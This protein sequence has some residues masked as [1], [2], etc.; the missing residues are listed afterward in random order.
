M[1]VRT[2]FI[3]I[4]GG[5]LA[6]VLLGGLIAACTGRQPVATPTPTRTPRPTETQ[7]PPATA[8]PIP[9][10][11]SA[12][13]ATPVATATPAAT[14]TPTVDVSLIVPGRDPDISPFTGLK[15]ADPKILERRPMAIK[16]ANQ[17]SVQPQSGLNKADIVVESPVEYSET[18]YTVLFHSQDAERVG[19]V[20]SARLIDVELPVIFDS[21][22]AYSGGVQPVLD[23]LAASD[24]G[25]QVLNETE[26]GIGFFRDPNI[27]VPDNLFANTVKLAEVVAKKGLN[28]R[29]QPAAGWVFSSAAP[30]GGAAANSVLL[31][32][33][34]FRVKWT[35]D[36][37]GGRW[38]REMG[39]TP[40]IDKV[41][42][43]QLTAANVVIFTAP[44]VKTLI[45]EHGTQ[46]QGEG[47]ACQNCSIEIQFWGE[48][49]VRVLR[50][51]KVYEGKWLRPE[52]HAPL[53]LV[54]AAGHD[55]PLKPGN[56]WWQF[57]PTDMKLTIAP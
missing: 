35:Y 14:A 31:P 7:A 29:P 44:H 8:T 6:L 5:L 42:G 54:D 1:S 4:C 18:R 45:L 11:T 52:R 21:V 57:I 37:A 17:Q 22:L 47:Q 55:I 51:G 36:A 10:A 53:R 40:H 33:P 50:D 23:K 48:G 41:T 20:R 26:A 13:T 27:V 39:G 2:R 28:R 34:R 56:S 46:M 3:F 38:K 19:S 9:T 30:A 24:I 25:R 12:A 43:E 15:P 32:Y 49:P 16:V